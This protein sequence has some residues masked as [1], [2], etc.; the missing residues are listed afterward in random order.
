MSLKASEWQSS[1]DGRAHVSEPCRQRDDVFAP[2]S[3]GVV[4]VGVETAH[5][6]SECGGEASLERA[7]ESVN[8]LNPRCAGDEVPLRHAWDLGSRIKGPIRFRGGALGISGRNAP[9]AGC[10]RL[11]VRRRQAV[12]MGLRAY[13]PGLPLG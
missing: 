7:L 5:V 13:R 12:K 2:V 3:R 10:A 1:G 11:A 6:P 9:F 4:I 8:R